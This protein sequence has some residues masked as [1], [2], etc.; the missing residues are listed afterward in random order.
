LL[1]QQKRLKVA[2]GMPEA[3]L[4]VKEMQ[5]MQVR[6]STFGQEQFACWREKEHDDLVLATALACWW[7][8]EHCW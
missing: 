7:A 5:A 2:G 4:L 6:Q 8:T 3:A 1:M